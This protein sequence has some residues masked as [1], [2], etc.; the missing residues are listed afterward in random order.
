MGGTYPVPEPEPEPEPAAPEPETVADPEV[1]EACAAT[2]KD[3]L[4]AKTWLI[5]VMFTAF[6]VYPSLIGENERQFLLLTP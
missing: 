3:P 5:S 4:L 2:E 1:V 6:T